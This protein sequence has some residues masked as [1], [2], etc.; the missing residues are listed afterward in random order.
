[1]KRKVEFCS[2]VGNLALVRKYVRNFLAE[3]GCAADIADLL[4]LG[5][6]E[7]CS[8]VIRHAYDNRDDQRI[9]LSVEVL[10]NKM[11]G[12]CGVRF[13]LRDYGPPLDPKKLNGR[14]L[15]DV[16]PGGLGLYFIKQVFDRAYYLRKMSAPS[17][18]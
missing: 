15:D 13:R 1:M 8:N 4:V 12:R 6:D 11:P 7:A 5:V 3:L 17:W 9:C 2:H 10:G 16:K 14:A 18:C